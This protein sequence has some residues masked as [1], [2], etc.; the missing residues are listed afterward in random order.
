MSASIELSRSKSGAPLR[1]CGY[2]PILPGIS[3]L[4]CIS[5]GIRPVS[6]LLFAKDR[7]RQSALIRI[8]QDSLKKTK[9]PV[10]SNTRDNEY[11]E[12]HTGKHHLPPKRRFRTGSTLADSAIYTTT[13][14]TVLPSLTTAGRDLVTS[15]SGLAFL[16]YTHILPITFSHSC[17][18]KKPRSPSPCGCNKLS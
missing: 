11:P 5:Y 10:V 16:Q 4:G 7:A 15:F 8:E 17:M 13:E 14:S 12:R 9:M 6:V 18:D 1:S 2:R 3:G